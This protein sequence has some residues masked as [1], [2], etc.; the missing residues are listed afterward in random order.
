MK[1]ISYSEKFLRL[2]FQKNINENDFKKI[3][4]KHHDSIHIAI[5]AT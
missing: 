4:S 2:N 3:F 1:E 5:I